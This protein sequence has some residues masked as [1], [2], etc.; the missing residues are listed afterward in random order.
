MN[1]YFKDHLKRMCELNDG[2]YHLG[3]LAFHQLRCERE[4]EI[5]EDDQWQQAPNPTN[6]FLGDSS[7]VLI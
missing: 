1:P 7:S 5:L 6:F 2:V 4:L 3:S